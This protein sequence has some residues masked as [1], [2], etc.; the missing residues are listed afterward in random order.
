MS[1]RP[2]FSLG[3]SEFNA[4]LFAVVGEEKNGSELTVLSALARLDLDPWEEA[5]RLSGLTEEAATAAL[6]AAIHSLPGDRWKT[7]DARSI[8]GRLVG[9]LPGYAG[10]PTRPSPGKK[11][12]IKMQLP[13]G[14]KWLLVT[15]LALAAVTALSHLLNL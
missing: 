12:G 6:S 15:G 4:F 7:S 14:Q 8:A 11:T 2:E 3:Q 5:A 9:H 1:L 13:V 10:S